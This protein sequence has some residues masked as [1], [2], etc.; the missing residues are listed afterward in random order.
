MK[1]LAVVNLP[2]GKYTGYWKGYWIRIKNKV[3]PTLK[4]NP[5]SEKSLQITVMN[6]RASYV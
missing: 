4:N 3:Y 1:Q 6:K 5:D 2:N